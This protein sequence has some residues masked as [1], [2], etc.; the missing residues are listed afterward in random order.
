MFFPLEVGGRLLGVMSVQ[1]T[2]ATV[3]GEREAG[4]LPHA[5]RW[6]AI[7]LDNATTY[8]AVAEQKQQLRVAAVAFESQEAMLVADAQ[9][10]H[11]PRQQRLLPHHR[12]SRRRAHR[13]PP[14]LFQLRRQTTARLRSAA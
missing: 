4:H 6:G 12:L 14:D 9:H 1:S 5:V 8:N 11:P 2:R 3:Y 13:P 10:Q 7:G